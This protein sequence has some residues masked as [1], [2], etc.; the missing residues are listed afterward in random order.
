MTRRHLTAGGALLASL[1][2]LGACSGGGDGMD[3]GAAQ[4]AGPE[5]G[6]SAGEAPDGLAPEP[7]AAGE[8]ASKGR[9]RDGSAGDT[10]PALGRAVLAQR[11]VIS[12][13]S[14]ILRVEDVRAAAARAEDAVVAAG[15]YVT[16]EETTA[17]PQR[18]GRT[19]SRLTFKVPPEE[20]RDVLAAVARLG[21]LRGQT[22]APRT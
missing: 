16:A 4:V 8:D 13:A 18:G 10:L 2:L 20:F 21:Q 19:V 14:V 22:H 9:G 17:D 15:G 6:G 3:A 7:G 5:N 11:R 1:V 12:T